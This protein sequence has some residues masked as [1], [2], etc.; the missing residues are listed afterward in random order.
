MYWRASSMARVKSWSRPTS[1]RLRLCKPSRPTNAKATT[2]SATITSSNVKPAAAFDSSLLR[3]VVKILIAGRD[4][5]A[6]GERVHPQ[7]E[8]VLA[9]VEVNDGEVD[10]P[11]GIEV[12]EDEPFVQLADGEGQHHVGDGDG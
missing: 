8:G 9:I 12:R 11:V 4:V 6:S 5:D 7:R 2:V 10:D 1:A 3:G